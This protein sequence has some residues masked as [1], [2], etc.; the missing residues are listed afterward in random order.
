MDVQSILRSICIRQHPDNTSDSSARKDLLVPLQQVTTGTLRRNLESP[1]NVLHQH[2]AQVLFV[3]SI[4]GAVHL[5]ALDGEQHLQR[6]V[7]GVV[8]HLLVLAA[9][10]GVRQEHPEC[11]VVLSCAVSKGIG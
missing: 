7:Q 8:L 3:Q 1:V 11:I 10:G 9:Q 2:I 5:T 4:D 6:Q